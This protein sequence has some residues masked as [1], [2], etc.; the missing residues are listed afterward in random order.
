MGVGGDMQER[1]LF[2]SNFRFHQPDRR[3]RERTNVA[4]QDNPGLFLLIPSLVPLSAEETT[5]LRPDGTS[6]K[7]TILSNWSGREWLR[8]IRTGSFLETLRWEGH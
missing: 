7:M 6:G 3:R 1:N 8:N 5:P 4:S 2:A